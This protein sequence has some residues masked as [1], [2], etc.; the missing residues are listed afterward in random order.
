LENKLQ[1][2]AEAKYILETQGGEQYVKNLY[3]KHMGSEEA[4][5]AR[6]GLFAA[7]A[8]HE[9]IVEILSGVAGERHETM[10]A[11]SMHR[12]LHIKSDPNQSTLVDIERSFVKLGC[13]LLD[14]ATKKYLNTLQSLE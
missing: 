13:V 11:I 9:R 10:T 12:L 8:Y 14:E 3:K 7:S 4:E 6:L 5:A 2:F 1:Y